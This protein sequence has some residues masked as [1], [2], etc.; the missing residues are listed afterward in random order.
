MEDNDALKD[1]I[2]NSFVLVRYGDGDY[3]TKQYPASGYQA[4]LSDLGRVAI[5]DTI[6]NCSDV[7]FDSLYS[8]FVDYVY[9]KSPILHFT[10]AVASDVGNWRTVTEANSRR[11]LPVTIVVYIME[12]PHRFSLSS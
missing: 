1:G 5:V 6:G 2:Y 10:D 11:N 8:I 12:M 4:F 7:T 3:L 9:D